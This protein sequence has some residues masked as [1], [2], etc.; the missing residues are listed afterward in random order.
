MAERDL[1]LREALGIAGNGVE[2]EADTA[3][4]DDL[5]SSDHPR[6]TR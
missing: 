4:L 1:E 5:L 2:R 3:A 6:D